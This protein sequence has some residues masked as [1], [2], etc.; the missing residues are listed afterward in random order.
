MQ[1]T[2]S[3][4]GGKEGGDVGHIPKRGDKAQGT[5]GCESTAREETHMDKD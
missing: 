2:D 5:A 1:Q 4:E 3:G